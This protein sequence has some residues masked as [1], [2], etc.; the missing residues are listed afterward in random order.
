MN[1][2]TIEP[3]ARLGG[4]IS[5]YV[6]TARAVQAARRSFRTAG[7]LATRRSGPG[8]SL[9]VGVQLQ[10]GSLNEEPVLVPAALVGVV[11]SGMHHDELAIPGDVPPLHGVTVAR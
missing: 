9:L 4:G 2:S 6:S 10:A 7:S 5:C 8:T 11:T 1:I 3:Y